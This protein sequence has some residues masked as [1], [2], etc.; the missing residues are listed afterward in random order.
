MTVFKFF[1]E[2]NNGQFVHKLI[3]LLEILPE[4]NLFF[5]HNLQSDNIT[6]LLDDHVEEFLIW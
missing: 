5:P 3:N 2:D 4:N 6:M 1:F